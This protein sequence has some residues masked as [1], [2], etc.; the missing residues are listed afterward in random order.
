MDNTSN[1]AFSLYILP[2]NIL[3]ESIADSISI[4]DEYT[5][6]NDFNGSNW[7]NAALIPIPKRKWEVNEA[8]PTKITIPES[9]ERIFVSAFLIVTFTNLYSGDVDSK[10]DLNSDIEL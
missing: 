9:N 4:P 5:S 7:S 3:N 2:D 6:N 10:E 8:S 1:S